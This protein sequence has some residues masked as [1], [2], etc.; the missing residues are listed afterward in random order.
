M[1]VSEQKGGQS[2]WRSSDKAS[3]NLHTRAR[4]A[5][6]GGA[7]G[8]LDLQGLPVGTGLRRGSVGSGRPPLIGCAPRES[9]PTSGSTLRE[10]NSSGRLG[11]SS[12]A[13]DR[14]KGLAVK[15]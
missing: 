5:I 15:D 11:P 1:G 6:A 7:V 14:A 2:N 9:G 10:T 4:V 3:L 8:F 12:T 13:L